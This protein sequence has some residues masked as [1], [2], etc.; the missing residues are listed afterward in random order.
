MGNSM[1]KYI[2]VLKMSCLNKQ[3]FMKSV[4]AEV[5]HRQ[6]K[7]HVEKAVMEVLKGVNNMANE[8]KRPLQAWD[9]NRRHT[10]RGGGC[11]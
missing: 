7:N 2:K 8:V 10:G 3:A 5:L 11:E 9:G 1:A 6:T 4:N